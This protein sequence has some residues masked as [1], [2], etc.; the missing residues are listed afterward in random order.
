MA[1]HPLIY[2]YI[3]HIYHNI[4]AHVYGCQYCPM[5]SIS[6]SKAPFAILMADGIMLLLTRRISS[7]ILFRQRLNMRGQITRHSTNRRDLYCEAAMLWRHIFNDGQ[8]RLHCY[9]DGPG[10]LATSKSTN[11][12]R[13][14]ISQEAIIT[15]RN[16]L[17]IRDKGS[18][19]WTTLLVLKNAKFTQ[20]D[21]WRHLHL[22]S[23]ISG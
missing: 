11:G 15:S 21:Q 19:D 4:A 5:K 6:N 17:P 20:F 18:G 2:I 14:T 1:F 7:L 23:T 10:V 13:E 8:S 22:P 3:Y 9:G 12:I 16:N